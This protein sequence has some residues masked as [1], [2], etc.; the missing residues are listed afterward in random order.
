MEKQCA[1]DQSLSKG[2]YYTPAI[3]LKT[4]RESLLLTKNDHWC[5]LQAKNDVKGTQTVDHKTKKINLETFYTNNINQ[6]D[7]IKNL[8]ICDSQ[9]KKNHKWCLS[10]IFWIILT[11]SRQIYQIKKSKKRKLRHKK[12]KTYSIM[13]FYKLKLHVCVAWSI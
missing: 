7:N 8:H 1:S 10:F 13:I 4:L 5:H 3:W 6:N 2:I 12:I 11:T 9:I